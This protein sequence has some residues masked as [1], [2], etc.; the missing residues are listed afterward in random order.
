MVTS[1]PSSWSVRGTAFALWLLVAASAVY[2]GL[3]LGTR[4]PALAAPAP[5]RA[6]VAV[7]PGAVA[8]LLGGSP[9][10]A[11][12]AAPSMASRFALVGVVAGA[13]SGSGAA[14]I[15]VDGKPAKPFRVGTAVEENLVVQSVEGRRAVLG[16]PGNGPAALTLELPL[17]PPRK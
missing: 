12:A 5:S 1:T 13:R 14:L 4:P 15:S 17:P 7:D 10:A 8:R 16:A 2:W 3:K 11:V 6:A 9:S